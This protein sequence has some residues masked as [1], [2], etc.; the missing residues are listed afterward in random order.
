MLEWLHVC[1]WWHNYNGWSNGLMKMPLFCIYNECINAEGVDWVNVCKCDFFDAHHNKITQVDGSQSLGPNG[2]PQWSGQN[3]SSFFGTWYLSNEP[4][5]TQG[6]I[7]PQ[8]TTGVLLLWWEIVQNAK[9]RI[10]W[11]LVFHPFWHPFCW[12]LEGKWAKMGYLANYCSVSP[13]VCCNAI[14]Y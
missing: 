13:H 4:H 3:I 10:G 1:E 12:F 2:P 5:S 9:I 8:N 7:S 11:N 6:L 14:L